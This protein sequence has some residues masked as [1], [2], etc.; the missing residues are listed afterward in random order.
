[1]RL[2]A[3]IPP[4]YR[5]TA[6]KKRF[7]L[8]P[9]IVAG[10]WLLDPKIANE[11]EVDELEGE[12]WRK[13]REVPGFP[14]QASAD[15]RLWKDQ[16]GR[17]QYQRAVDVRAALKKL[18]DEYFASARVALQTGDLA[19]AESDGRKAWAADPRSM[20]PR[21]LIAACAAARS[22]VEEV[23]LV[24]AVSE[25]EGDLQPEFGLRV[26]AFAEQIPTCRDQVRAIAGILDAELRAFPTCT[27]SVPRDI[28]DAIGF[29][30]WSSDWRSDQLRECSVS[31]ADA[32]FLMAFLA[33]LKEVNRIDPEGNP[34]ARID[35]A[36]TV[37]RESLGKVETGL[38]HYFQDELRSCL[39]EYACPIISREDIKDWPELLEFLT[40]SNPIADAVRSVIPPK[41]LSSIEGLQLESEVSPELQGKVLSIL[42]RVI[43][44]EP[45]SLDLDCASDELCTESPSSTSMMN[46]QRLE[47]VLPSTLARSRPPLS[48]V[49]S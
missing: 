23:R 2:I 41:L 49:R 24:K 22:A 17:F 13:F 26:L 37:W 39:E 30:D 21:A 5:D 8:P 48:F 34:L 32:A 11:D 16:D 40:G 31:G 4:V 20:E 15:Y 36:R 33:I 28:A 10:K 35:G 1:M 9:Y 46:R 44:E 45:I 19:K 27:F 12:V 6:E 18:R 3:E 38:S 29:L 43:F 7:Y 42:N 14:V 25:A 47:K